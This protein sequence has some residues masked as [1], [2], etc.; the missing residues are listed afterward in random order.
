MQAFEPLIK[1][2]ILFILLYCENIEIAMVIVLFNPF[3][4]NVS[5]LYSLTTVENQT[6][7]NLQRGYKK[8]TLGRNGL[9]RLI[10]FFP[11][12]LL[13]RFVLNVSMF[14]PESIRK[15]KGKKQVNL[16]VLPVIKQNLCYWMH[17]LIGIIAMHYYY[18]HQ[19]I[20]SWKKRKKFDENNYVIIFVKIKYL[21]DL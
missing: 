10:R 13:I 3:L 16:Q 7:S 2:S 18:H 9:K 19:F 1:I 14:S 8:E 4:P 12:F 6:F 20:L 15:S 5:V 17:Q 11:M 21:P